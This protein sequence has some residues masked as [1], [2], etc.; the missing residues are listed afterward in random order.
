MK[1]ILKITGITIAV[2]LLVMLVL[3]FAFKGKILEVA[4]TELNKN[5]NAKVDFDRLS[6]NFFRSF[7]NATASLSNF[8]V[9]G[10]E[11]FEGDTLLHVD[12]FS[13][14]IN[15]KSLFGNSG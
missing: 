2:I 10:I 8:S 12:N 3:P 13:A 1:K 4:K 14:T 7:P 15:L 11:E 9:V 6:L 5:L